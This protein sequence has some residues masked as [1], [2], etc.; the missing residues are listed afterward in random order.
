MFI[1][2]VSIYFAIPILA[3]LISGR[4][5]TT[6]GQLLFMFTWPVL[7]MFDKPEELP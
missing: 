3:A 2:I 5:M 1:W 7:W 4:E 6:K